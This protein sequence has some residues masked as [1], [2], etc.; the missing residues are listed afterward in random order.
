MPT[1]GHSWRY[2][3]G[4]ADWTLTTLA[5]AADQNLHDVVPVQWNIWVDGLCFVIWIGVLLRRWRIRVHDEAVVCV[6]ISRLI[7]RMVTGADTAPSIA[8]AAIT[9]WTGSMELCLWS[10]RERYIHEMCN[11]RLSTAGGGITHCG[12]D[13]KCIVRVRV[14]GP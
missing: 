10:R 8:T 9:T 7:L 1:L 2:G 6:D 11:G 4:Q 3:L 5:L 14:A 12:G 13:C